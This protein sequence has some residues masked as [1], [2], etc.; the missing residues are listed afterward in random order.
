[1]RS[2]SYTEPT[3]NDFQREIKKSIS[4]LPFTVSKKGEYFRIK[5]REP[6]LNMKNNIAATI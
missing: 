4:Y 2:L 1:M 3:G 5:S 6:T